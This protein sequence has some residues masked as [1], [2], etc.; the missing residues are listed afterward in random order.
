MSL[1][2]SN[3]QT[4]THRFI[5]IAFE[6]DVGC[7]VEFVQN[8]RPTKYRLF[9]L[10]DLVCT[11]HLMELKIKNGITLTCSE[12]RFFGGPRDFQRNILKRIKR[13]EI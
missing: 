12:N 9:Q 11:L 7:P 2:D 6:N 4:P 1:E 10:A 8:V 13:K 5:F 3:I